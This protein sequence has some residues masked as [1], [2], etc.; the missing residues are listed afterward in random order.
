MQL[1]NVQGMT[2]GHCVKGVT[3]AIQ[4]QD[5]T[6]VVQVNLPQGEVSV[7]SQLTTQTI[8]DL[9]EQEGYAVQVAS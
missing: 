7:Q 6:A 1:F 5:P 8:I 9:I 4:T 3:H 2:C